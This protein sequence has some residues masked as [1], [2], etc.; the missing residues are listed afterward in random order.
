MGRPGS[1]RR[2]HSRRTPHEA[3]EP[4]AAGSIESDSLSLR[5][6]AANPYTFDGQRDRLSIEVT[7]S[8]GRGIRARVLRVYLVVVLGISLLSV[9]VAMVL[10]YIKG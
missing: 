7:M 2:Q 6:V 8:H 9:L 5:H 4:Q 3:V 1:H 10:Q